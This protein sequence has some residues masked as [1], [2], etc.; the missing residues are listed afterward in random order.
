[1]NDRW[2]ADSFVP[3]ISKRHPE[4]TRLIRNLGLALLWLA[5]DE[6]ALA[7]I[8]MPELVLQRIVDAYKGLAVN[9]KPRQPVQKVPLHVYCHGKETVVEEVLAGGGQ[10]EQQASNVADNLA[11]IPGSSGSAATQQVLQTV[12][13]QQ[14]AAVP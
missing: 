6:Q 4:D 5:H 8:G 11:R 14:R 1:V 9:E 3:N 10:Q 13:V 2:I 12:V 7:D